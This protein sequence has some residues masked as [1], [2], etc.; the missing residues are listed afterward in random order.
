M[1]DQARNFA[2]GEQLKPHSNAISAL[3]TL[4]MG[5]LFW[6]ADWPTGNVPRLGAIVYTVWDRSNCLIY[7]GMAGRSG[8]ST[9]GGGP[10]G[11]L[12]SHAGGRRSGDQFCIY[13]CDRFVL[14]R[15]LDR[16]LEIAAGQLSLDRL[17]REFIRA[18]LGF[19]FIAVDDSA[20]ALT[21]ERTIQK[22][23]L[24]AGKPLLNPQS[25]L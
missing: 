6:F 2:L 15:V 20:A 8:T 4:E 14:P 9:N 10:Y 7:T 17:T 12:A 19:R 16:I 25:N 18:E 23:A 1:N 21:I 24:R 5:P 3:D 13:V 22:G 11:R